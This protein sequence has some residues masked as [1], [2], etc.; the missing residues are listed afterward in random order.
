MAAAEQV[1]DERNSAAHPGAQV[2]DELHI[3]H[4][5]SLVAHHS[6]VFWEV[7]VKQAVA[8]GFVVS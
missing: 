5:L 6:A 4:L 7:I 3:E 1:R 8:V 2:T